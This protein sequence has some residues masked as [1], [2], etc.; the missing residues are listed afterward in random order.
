M[1]FLKRPYIGCANKRLVILIFKL[2]NKITSKYK[3]VFKFMD[4]D[5]YLSIF[6]QKKYYLSINSIVQIIYIV[7][8]K[9]ALINDNELRF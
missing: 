4:I 7:R 8:Y 6:S 2:I 3:F 1:R 9:R 5:Y